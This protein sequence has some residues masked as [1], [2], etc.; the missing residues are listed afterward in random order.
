MKQLV[1]TLV[2]LGSITAGARACPMC[3]D[4]VPNQEG[5]S[6]GLRD[7]YDAGGQNISGGMNASVYVMLGALFG[8]IGLVSTVMVKGIRS[9]AASQ[10]RGFPVRDAEHRA[11]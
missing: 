10:Q 6:A 5:A 3:K 2:I 8:A 1:A 9:A 11:E 4:S 7:S